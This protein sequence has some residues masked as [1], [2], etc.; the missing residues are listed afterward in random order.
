MSTVSATNTGTPYKRN[1]L[2]RQLPPTYRHLISEEE[3]SYLRQ[4]HRLLDEATEN[5]SASQS[6]L[7]VDLDTADS[8]HTDGEVS[9]ARSSTDAEDISLAAADEEWFERKIHL[10]KLKAACSKIVRVGRDASVCQ[11][12]ICV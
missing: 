4:I 2:H 12:Q 6:T 5:S 8:T 3:Q 10:G 9:S 7:F 1:R 11:N